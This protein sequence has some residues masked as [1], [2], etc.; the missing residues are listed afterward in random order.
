[1]YLLVPTEKNSCVEGPF[2]MESVSVF[3]KGFLFETCL[4]PSSDPVINPTDWDHLKCNSP[5]LE[6]GVFRFLSNIAVLHCRFVQN[7]CG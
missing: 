6:T 5:H 1:M 7:N 3:I 4:A 2:D